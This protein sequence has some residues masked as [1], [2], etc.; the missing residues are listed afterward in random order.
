MTWKGKNIPE[1]KITLRKHFG[2]TL[3][4]KNDLRSSTASFQLNP[5]FVMIYDEKKS[6]STDYKGDCAVDSAPAALNLPQLCCLL[7]LKSEKWIKYKFMK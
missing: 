4:F 2:H 6:Q 7:L 3:P 5:P 1:L